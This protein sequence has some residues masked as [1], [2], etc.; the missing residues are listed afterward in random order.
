MLIVWDSIE[1]N[2]FRWKDKAACGLSMGK[3][4]SVLAAIWF[5]AAE[6]G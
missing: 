3:L 2:L 6:T 4:A 5:L 1:M